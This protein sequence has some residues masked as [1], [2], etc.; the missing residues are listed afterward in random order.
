MLTGFSSTLILIWLLNE[1]H[2]SGINFNILGYV[3]F[4]N[5][6][7]KC[8]E[9]KQRKSIKKEKMKKNKK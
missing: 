3:W 9:K 6:E 4:E 7:G 5:F 1:L 8:K 2:L